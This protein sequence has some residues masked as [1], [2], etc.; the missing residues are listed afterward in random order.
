MSTDTPKDYRFLYDEKWLKAFH[1][2]GKPTVV[3]IEAVYGAELVGDGGQKTRKPGLKFKGKELPF[4]I[5]KTDGRTIASLYGRDPKGW[6]GK[7]IELYPT[8]T[9]RGPETVECIRVRAP[10]GGQS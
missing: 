2:Q 7:Q 5:C 10:N 4:A 8:T 9:R 3:T 1:L 6:I